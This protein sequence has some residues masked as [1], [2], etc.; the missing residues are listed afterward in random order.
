RAGQRTDPQKVIDRQQLDGKAPDR[1]YG[2]VQR[3]R[4]D[5]RVH[6]RAVGQTRVDH[7]RGFVDAAADCR[8][9]AIDDV[10]QMLIVV[11][12]HFRAFEL[13]PAFVLELPLRPIHQ[14]VGYRGVGQQWLE[15][16]VAH[17][18]VFDPADDELAL[19]EA[20]R[21]G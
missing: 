21:S 18:L 3:Q 19:T 6:A 14:Y 12:A 15:G 5:D 13:S 2:S 20:Q 8:N 4:R 10:E 7:G 1:Q 9:D 16:P 11:E 17:D